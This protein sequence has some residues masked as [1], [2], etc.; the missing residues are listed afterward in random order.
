[1]VKILLCS[2]RLC[3]IDKNLD[4][5]LFYAVTVF[6]DLY[7]EASATAEIRFFN[8]DILLCPTNP[9]RQGH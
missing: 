8:A 1:M 3:L 4:M 5:S 6:V 7:D 2:N 9:N